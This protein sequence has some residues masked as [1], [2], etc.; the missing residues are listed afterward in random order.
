M[1]KKDATTITY[2]KNG[3]S[4]S[5]VEITRGSMV[6][7]VNESGRDMWPASAM[8]PT[9]MLY[10]GSDIKKCGTAGESL[11]FDACKGIKNGQDWSFTFDQ[12]GA[13]KFHDH[14]TPSYFGTITV[15]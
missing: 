5:S 8:H 11:I 2:T 15:K 7:F 10:P 14:L 4:P 13:W 12:A 1:G 6:T 9:H 3:F